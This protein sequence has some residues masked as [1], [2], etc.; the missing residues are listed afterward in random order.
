MVPASGRVERGSEDPIAV[1]V[2]GIVERVRGLVDTLA[3][4]DAKCEMRI[5]SETHLREA[6]D[7]TLHEVL[8][9]KAMADGE[10]ETKREKSDDY[11]RS[12]ANEWRNSLK[13]LSDT[14][15]S[16]S[17]LASIEQRLNKVEI[18]VSGIPDR[19]DIDRRFR[20]VQDIGQARDTRIQALE[21]S[22]AASAS[23]SQERRDIR[24]TSIGVWGIVIAIASIV[25]SLI[26]SLVVHNT[27]S[28]VPGLK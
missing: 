12:Q 17:E 5:A 28:S 26:V 25:G 1:Q 18:T 14:M 22:R 27:V 21:Q 4:L 24:Q 16:H 10:A 11:A 3:A 23:Q 9:E 2:A 7:H 20:E 8:V 6:A 19:L 15:A 13:D